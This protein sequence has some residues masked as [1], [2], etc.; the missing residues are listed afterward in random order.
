MGQQHLEVG[1]R[2]GD[3][4]GAADRGAAHQVERGAPELGAGGGGVGGGGAQRA[5]QIVVDGAGLGG[6]LGSGRDR[7]GRGGGGGGG[8]GGVGS[9]TSPSPSPYSS[10]TPVSIAPVGVVSSGRASGIFWGEVGAVL[11]GSALA[12]AG[13]AQLALAVGLFSA[14]MSAGRGYLALVAVVLA[15]WRPGRA[16]LVALGIGVADALTVRLQLHAGAVPRELAQLLPYALTL[17]LLAW[18]GA[19]RA[20]PAA[21]G[22]GE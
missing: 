20:P 5:A 14:E 19:G 3:R 7:A 10:P 11:F 4:R 18:R 21:L 12:G 17:A 1:D 15:G 16:A 8:G 6:G 13:G 22:R 2:A 9:P